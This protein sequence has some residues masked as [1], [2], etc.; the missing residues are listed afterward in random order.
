MAN[1]H[2]DTYSS[3]RSQL[4]HTLINHP[5]LILKDASIDHP[6][7]YYGTLHI[8]TRGTR[9]LFA[10]LGRGD[11]ANFQANH[12]DFFVG[13]WVLDTATLLLEHTE[14]D[15]TTRITLDYQSNVRLMATISKT[16]HQS[17]IPPYE[18]PLWIDIDD[19]GYMKH[20]KLE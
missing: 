17:W 9:G 4:I 12:K 6:S 2:H 10:W 3:E 11:D 8:E 20:R 5:Y 1:S 19:Q 18:R 15:C 13:S 14:H 7:K 16:T